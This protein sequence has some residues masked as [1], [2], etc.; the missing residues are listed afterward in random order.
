MRRDA[1]L[2]AAERADI[3]ADA[4]VKLERMLSLPNAE[5]VTVADDREARALAALK[6]DP[7]VRYAVPNVPLRIAAD[8]SLSD[9]ADP[10]YPF[11]VG[12]RA[13]Q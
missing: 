9:P 5:L 11:A 8:Q 10:T 1:G 7:D 2:S 13:V 3:R 4:G 6:A 12:A